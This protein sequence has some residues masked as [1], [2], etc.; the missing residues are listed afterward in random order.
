MPQRRRNASIRRS[1]Q[2]QARSFRLSRRLH[3]GCTPTSTPPQEKHDRDS[4]EGRALRALRE[5]RVAADPSWQAGQVTLTLSFIRSAEQR[6]F[7]GKAW[8]VFLERWCKLVRKTD[9]YVEIF[10]SVTTLADLG[11]T[12]TWPATRST[13][14]TCRCGGPRLLRRRPRRLPPRPQDVPRRSPA[15]RRPGPPPR[16]PSARRP[17]SAA[18][19]ESI[20]PRSAPTWGARSTLLIDEQVALGDPGPPLAR[21]LVAAGHVD[22]VDRVVDQLPAVLRRQVVPAALDEEQLG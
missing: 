10:G 18:R 2:A 9:R 11:Q 21:H 1:T 5:I 3:R 16:T 13:S 4:D 17:A 6:D 15:P 20:T 14:T 22:H 8:D 7:E 19:R 12:S